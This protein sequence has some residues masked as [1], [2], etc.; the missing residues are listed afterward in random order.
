MPG[1]AGRFLLFDIDEFDNWLSSISISRQIKLIQNH[2]TWN[3]SYADFHGNNH[4]NLLNGMEAAHIERGFTEIAQ[5][6]TIFPDGKLAV[7][8]SLEKIPAGIKGA[9]TSGIC[10]ENI[11][12]FDNGHDI[13]SDMH[14]T[15]II[16][17]VAFLCKKF[18][19]RPSSGSIIYH[20]WYDL[21]TGKR[22]NGSGSTKTCPGT[23]FFGGNSVNDAETSFIPFVISEIGTEISLSPPFS[24]PIFSGKVKSESLNVRSSSSASSKIVKTLNKGV[25]ISAY[26]TNGNWCRIDPEK[27]LWI[28]SNFIEH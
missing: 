17:A 21:D 20:H 18:H 19:L 4:F 9:N 28:N 2:H 16:K 12:N 27:Q 14:K 26:E 13:M 15:S 7:C 1:K 25:I 8:R 3:P 10:I 6:I 23:G 22:T 5:N 24:T 11:G